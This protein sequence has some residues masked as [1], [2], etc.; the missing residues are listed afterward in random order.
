MPPP[1]TGVRH[2]LKRA[3]L[4]R[5]APNESLLPFMARPI[6]SMVALPQLTDIDDRFSDFTMR[7]GPAKRRH[8]FMTRQILPARFPWPVPAPVVVSFDLTWM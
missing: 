6:G 5:P 4:N 8:G 3:R 1:G 7:A 2:T